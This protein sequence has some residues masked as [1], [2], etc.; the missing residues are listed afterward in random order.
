VALGCQLEEL[1]LA[2]E[3]AINK[4]DL[5]IRAAQERCGFRW[6]R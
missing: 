2:W 6:Q 1:N 4:Y 5:P 3:E